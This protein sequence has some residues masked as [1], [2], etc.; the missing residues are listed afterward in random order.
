MRV[1]PRLHSGRH[2][3]RQELFATST[4][5][6]AQSEMLE[7]PSTCPKTPPSLFTS[8]TRSRLQ[9]RSQIGRRSIRGLDSGQ[10]LRKLQKLSNTARNSLK[11]SSGQPFSGSLAG[12][13]FYPSTLQSRRNS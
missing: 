6:S 12:P 7:L 2:G 4:T 10:T 5:I 3:K 13:A 11:L 9:G 1:A 8:S